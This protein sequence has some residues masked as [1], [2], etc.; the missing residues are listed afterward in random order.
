MEKKLQKYISQNALLK[1]S[2]KL[3]VGIS[4]GA[5]SCALLHALH[6]LGYD[7]IVAH[8]NFHLRGKESMRDEKFVEELAKKYKLPF[9][10]IDFQTTEYAAASKIS[11]EMAARDLRYEWFEKIR[12]KENADWIVVAHH[13]NDTV[14]TV[15]M[16]LTRGTGIN[17]LTGIKPKNGF[18][19]R[20]ML[21]VSRSEILTYIKNEKLDFVVDSTNDNTAFIRNR[22]REEIIPAFE[23]INPSFSSNLLQTVERL[24]DVAFV[25]NDYIQKAKDKICRSENDGTFTISIKELSQEKIKKSILFEIL[26][27]FNFN[28]AQS[29]DIINNID[30]ESGRQFFSSTHRLLKDRNNLIIT[31]LPD[32]DLSECNKEKYPS[33]KMEFFDKTEDFTIDT[34]PFVAFFDS[35]KIRVPFTIRRWQNGDAF[36]PLGMNVKKKVSDYLIDKKISRIEKDNTWILLSGCGEIMWIVGERIDNRFKITEETKNILKI[37]CK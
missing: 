16:N 28:S 36:Y 3:I 21:C 5:D 35:E 4:G 24:E 7:I 31:N 1:A 26:K 30:G 27:E 37:I 15:L 32:K 19:V 10:K 25:Y 33:I 29:S 14:E 22:F 23:K 18:V 6:S 34:S 2:D 12:K 11:I 13:S 9:C 17:G 8:C 20:P